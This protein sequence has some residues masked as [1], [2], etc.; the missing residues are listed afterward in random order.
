LVIFLE[1]ANQFEK[2]NQTGSDIDHMKSASGQKL[3]P[4]TAKLQ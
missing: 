1:T 4:A 2:T 3:K